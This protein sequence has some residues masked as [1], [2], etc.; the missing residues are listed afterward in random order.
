MGGGFI[1][2]E[3]HV[4]HPLSLKIVGF[5]L[6]NYENNQKQVVRLIP[7]KVLTAKFSKSV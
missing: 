3:G 1:V 7:V 6:F 4:F 5:L 2:I